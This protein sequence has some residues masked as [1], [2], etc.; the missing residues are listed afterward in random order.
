MGESLADR[1]ERALLE[2]IRRLVPSG[3]RVLV[4]PGDDTAVVASGRR[5]LL[6]TTDALVEGV[7]FR[8]TWLTA[9]A[10]GRR[11]FEV[12]A[13]DIAAMG[14]RPVAA[15]LAVVAPGRFPAVGLR[16]VVR[17]VRDGAHAVGAALAG[18][19][20]AH[21]RQLSLTVALLGEAVARP[22]GRATARV[23]DQLF[24]TGALGGAALGVRRLRRGHPHDAAVA[25]W[26]RPVARL[27]AG[28][29]LARRGLATAMIDLSDGLLVDCDR[30][31]VASGVGARIHVDQVPRARALA[32]L[33]PAAGRTLV[34]T[35]GED[36]ELLFAV[37]PSRLGALARAR[38]ALGCPIT[39]IGELVRG[40]GLE[41][42][43]DRGRI[44]PPPSRLGHL[45]F[46]PG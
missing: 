21:G 4:G 30:V 14:G 11:A 41:L 10:L 31:C 16:D 33:G 45:H 39:R 12:N 44:V 43:D 20:L 46:R 13:S 34:L 28:E 35:G 42:V 7:H 8:R 17:G 25:R 36:Y 32:E 24:V 9:R 23:G 2:E 19:N 37:R 40:R 6:L 27:R 22:I 18:G 5:P 26:R 15:L 3:R 29:C 38:R 1:G